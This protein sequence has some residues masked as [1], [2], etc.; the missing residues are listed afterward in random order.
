MFLWG[1]G[2]SGSPVCQTALELVKQ[3]GMTL[4][5]CSSCLCICNA[6]ILGVCCHAPCALYLITWPAG[7]AQTKLIKTHSRKTWHTY[8]KIKQIILFCRSHVKFKLNWVC[9]FFLFRFVLFKCILTPLGE[10]V[11]LLTNLFAHAY[12]VA[13]CP[14]CMVLELAQHI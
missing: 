7:T 9:G 2:E 4:N 6:G 10:D 12:E 3:P 1:E 13:N 8:D 14:R 11:S 5:F